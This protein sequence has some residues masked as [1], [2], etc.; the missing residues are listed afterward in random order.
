MGEERKTSMVLP[1]LMDLIAGTAKGAA[2]QGEK[3]GYF[4]IFDPEPDQPTEPEITR[5]RLGPDSG[6]EFVGERLQDGFEGIA[7]FSC[8][9]HEEGRWVIRG[10]V[11][12]TG[13]N[14]SASGCLPLKRTLLGKFRPTRDKVELDGFPSIPGIFTSKADA[15]SKA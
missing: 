6:R 3:A 8:L 11:F 4:Q 14:V 10:E 15:E 9:T 1:V 13:T 7:G 12:E 2:V 5:H